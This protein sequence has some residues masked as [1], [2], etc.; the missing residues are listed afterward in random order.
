MPWGG[1]DREFGVRLV[2]S[3]I[4]PKHVRYNAIVIHLDH[5]RGYKDPQLMA[6]NKALRVSTEKR[7]I[8]S[9]THGIKQLPGTTNNRWI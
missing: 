3:G 4:K 9:T 8:T 1:L 5:K 7:R 2:N 6:A